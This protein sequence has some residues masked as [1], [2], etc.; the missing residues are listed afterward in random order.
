M[1]EMSH[2]NPVWKKQKNQN[3]K[4]RRRGQTDDSVG[5]EYAIK[6]GELHSFY[7]HGEGVNHLPLI[8]W[9]PDSI[10]ASMYLHNAHTH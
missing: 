6:P 5:K 9:P 8:T 10:V 2:N 4:I 1:R 7:S 3:L